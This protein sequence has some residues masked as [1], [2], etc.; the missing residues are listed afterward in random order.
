VRSPRSSK[1]TLRKATRS[2]GR[3]TIRAWRKRDADLLV[4]RIN[5]PLVAAF[6]DQ[7]PHPYTH[8]DARAWFELADDRWR[9]GTM[10]TFALELE[11]LEGPVGGVGVHF[12][13]GLDAGSAEIGYW[14]AEE[15]RGRGVATAATRLAATWAF[16]SRSDLVRLQLRADVENAASNRVAEKAGFTREGVLR[17]QRYNERLGRRSDFVMWSLLRE[18]P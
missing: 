10:A 11:T 5:D 12:F 2:D 14:V 9:A 7:L 6:L 3:V 1:R 13:D 15:V 8:E 18:E 17:S 4:E 16:E